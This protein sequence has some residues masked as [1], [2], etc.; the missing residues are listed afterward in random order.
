MPRLHL[1]HTAIAILTAALL[2]GIAAPATDAWGMPSPRAYRPGGPVTL[3][4][5]LLS[6]SGT[7]AWAIDQYLAANTPLPALGAAFMAAER[8]Y[9]VNA[10]FLLAAAMHES[11]LGTSYIARVKHNLFGY[12]A[13]DRDPFRYATAYRTFA[14]NIAATAKFIRDFYLTRTGRWWGGAPTLRSMQQFWSSSGGWGVSVSRVANSIRLA[15]ISGSSYRFGT[16]A[17]S[18]GSHGGDPVTLSLAWSGGAIPAGVTFVAVWQPVELDADRAAAATASAAALAGSPGD[19]PT[20]GSLEAARPPVTVAASRLAGGP[21]TVTLATKAP[22]QPGRYLLS[23][24]MRDAGGTP[25]PGGQRV[26]IPSVPLRVWADAA[27]SVGLAPTADGDG[28]TVQ[29]TNT[30]R[31]PIPAEPAPAPGGRLVGEPESGQD[32]SVV[33]VTA[34][35]A[36]D[37]SA[38][39]LVL[40]APLAADLLPGETATFVAT[41]IG[42][43]TGRSGNW[44]SADLSVLGDPMLLA[45]YEPAPAWVSGP[46][47]TG[48]AM[49]GGTAWAGPSGPAAASTRVAVPSGVS[50]PT[51]A[52]V[53]TPAGTT[54]AGPAMPPPSGASAPAPIAAPANPA[55]APASASAATPAA[56][57]KPTPKPTPTPTSTPAAVPHTTRFIS[58]RSAAVSYRGSWGT[59]AGPYR[60]GA[61]AY[62]T[63]AGATASLRFTGT[64]VSWVGPLGPTRGSAQV[65]LDGR[66]VATVS[67]WRASFIGQATL[68]TRSFA[69][70]GSHTLTIR[71]LSAPGHPYV[72]IDGFTVRS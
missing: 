69:S 39:I 1:P 32:R 46:G 42:K 34:T 65:I 66:V 56:T 54:T 37:D 15:A 18:G 19:G 2:L 36:S 9:G 16:P 71:V 49:Q 55:I 67:L 35:G 63:S 53:P 59:A 58:E 21:R 28:V 60:G 50:A 3:D 48:A 62:S 47:A 44:L 14:A 13:Y 51:V 70:A 11:A 25:L 40:S 8:A 61:V 7:T 23:L 72:A 64:Q 5:N 52:A 12:N 45:A 24:E 17:V 41:G 33:T 68:F 10:K 6:R 57:P 20:A 26:A 27:V 31:L 30:G 29:V 38:P 4:T 22:G 43:L